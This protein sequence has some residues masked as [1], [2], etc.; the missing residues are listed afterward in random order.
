MPDVCRSQ[1]GTQEVF[2]EVRPWL[3]W[4]ASC[5]GWKGLQPVW[6]AGWER[7]GTMFTVELSGLEL[8]EGGYENDPTMRVKV[9]FPF[10]AAPALVVVSIGG[11]S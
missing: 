6:K 7:G 4:V 2:S 11:G 1:P 5:L 8:V 9:N 3:L 10:S